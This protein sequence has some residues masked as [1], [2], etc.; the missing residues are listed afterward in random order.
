VHGVCVRV[1]MAGLVRPCI[2]PWLG[3]FFLMLSLL[4][5][6]LQVLSRMAGQLSLHCP[7]LKSKDRAGL[8]VSFPEGMVSCKPGQVLGFLP[9]NFCRAMWLCGDGFVVWVVRSNR[10]G[11]LCLPWMWMMCVESMFPSV[12]LT[13]FVSRGRLLLRVR[14]RILGFAR[15]CARS[16]IFVTPLTPR[17]ASRQ[18]VTAPRRCVASCAGI[19]ILSQEVAKY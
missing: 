3:W 2:M 5:I 18:V 19:K 13:A 17:P 9:W 6:L 11:G 4:W 1:C 12:R 8:L 7:L 10:G 15:P 16:L 14:V